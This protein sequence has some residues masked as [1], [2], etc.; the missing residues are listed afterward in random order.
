MDPVLNERCTHV[1]IPYQ[2]T[3]YTEN[4]PK[5]LCPGNNTAYACFSDSSVYVLIAWKRESKYQSYLREEKD[6][7]KNDG[8]RKDVRRG[9][10]KI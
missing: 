2:S 9:S 7:T 4:V 5:F 3:N 10:R 6:M 8:V 1:S